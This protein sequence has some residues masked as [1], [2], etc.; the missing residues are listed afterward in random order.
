MAQENEERCIRAELLRY[1]YS[2]C[3]QH[4]IY[5]LTLATGFFIALNIFNI[6][7][8]PVT[9]AEDFRLMGS[10]IYLALVFSTFLVLEPYCILRLIL[11]GYLANSAIHNEV[12]S[13]RKSFK[14]I[15]D[16]FNNF[17]TAESCRKR[18]LIWILGRIK[19]L[20]FLVLAAFWF[21]LLI[22]FLILFL[23]FL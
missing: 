11:W 7:N 23:Y 10:G 5:V 3:T 2:E 9:I 21:A 4:S 19:G 20:S 22:F 13:F 8:F 6:G 16:E 12:V 15:H 18:A 17:G 14:L 1:Y